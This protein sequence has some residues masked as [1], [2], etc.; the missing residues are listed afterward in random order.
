MKPSAFMK[1]KMSMTDVVLKICKWMQSKTITIYSKNQLKCNFLPM[2]FEFLGRIFHAFYIFRTKIAQNFS[3]VLMFVLDGI[4]WKKG[5]DAMHFF[6]YFSRT[7]KENWTFENK[8]FS[9]LFTFK[10]CETLLFTFRELKNARD[11]RYRCNL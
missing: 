5:Q 6:L 7:T 2:P 8:Y 3:F 1:L 9:L 4:Q 10:C 11:S